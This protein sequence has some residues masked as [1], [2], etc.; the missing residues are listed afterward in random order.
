MPKK[1]EPKGQSRKILDCEFLRGWLESFEESQDEFKSQKFTSE[2]LEGLATRAGFRTHRIALQCAQ[3]QHVILKRFI[4]EPAFLRLWEI[5]HQCD[6]SSEEESGIAF[7]P[8]NGGFP[9]GLLRHV[10]WWYQAPKVTKREQEAVTKKMFK[11][12]DVLLTFLGQ[13]SPSGPSDSLMKL[14]RLDP[15]QVEELYRQFSTEEI[16]QSRMNAANAKLWPR[17]GQSEAFA[18]EAAGITPAFAIR[19]LQDNLVLG[20]GKG[21]RLPT[22]I[23]AA[24]AMKTQFIGVID[25]LLSDTTVFATYQPKFELQHVAEL[26][27]LTADTDCSLED[28]HKARAVNRNNEMRRMEDFQKNL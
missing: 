3:R 22:K 25:R 7:S 26:V 15:W 13:I 23:R 17:P 2:Q 24:G 18:L 6:L 19:S 16:Y 4:S 8:S 1:K 14:K 10:E 9:A 5:L 12:C 21:D 11:A 20:T 27:S 28:V